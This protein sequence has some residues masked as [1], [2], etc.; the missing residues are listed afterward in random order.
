MGTGPDRDP[1]PASPP[2][3][4]QPQQPQ[5]LGL[6][7]IGWLPATRGDRT[8]SASAARWRSRKSFSAA[9]EGAV[10]LVL[11]KNRTTAEDLLAAHHRLRSIATCLRY[12]PK[13]ELETVSSA[14][15]SLETLL[16]S[17][18]VAQE[19]Q[20]LMRQFHPTS[21]DQ[22]LK[23]RSRTPSKN[24]GTCMR[25]SCCSATTCLVYPRIT[26]NWKHSLDVC[27]DTSAGLV[28]VKL[29][30]NCVILAR[31]RSSSWQ[32]A[33]AIAQPNPAG[34]AGRLPALSS[35]F[36]TGGS[37]SSILLSLAP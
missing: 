7:R 9:T 13:P 2:G 23:S 17:Q 33:A 29:P 5:A 22:R 1:N 18:Q 34:P 19:M 27:A 30:V 15:H 36:G 8:R 24:V 20:A 32:I 31:L 11:A 35:A 21:Q 14:S 26:C 4:G 6:G 16:N 10:E 3:C 28:A 37:T 12:P 25:T